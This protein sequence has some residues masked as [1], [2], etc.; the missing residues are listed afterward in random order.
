[1]KDY[2]LNSNDSKEFILSYKIENGKIIAKLANKRLY[3][4]PYSKENESIIISKMENQA[5]NAKIKPLSKYDVEALKILPVILS[6]TIVNFIVQGGVFFALFL[7]IVAGGTIYYPT[8]VIIH[9]MKKRDIKR[10][11]YFLDHKEELNEGFE[12]SKNV[13]FDVSKKAVKEM[14]LQKSQNKQPFNINNIDNYSLNDLKTLRQNI[15]RISLFGL[16]E[17]DQL[18]DDKSKEKVKEKKKISSVIK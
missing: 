6:M 17:E 18:L 12:K 11:N 5:R 4:I 3:T 14:K 13:K 9:E 10:L 16:S 1:M 15:E 8:K 2:S 7:A